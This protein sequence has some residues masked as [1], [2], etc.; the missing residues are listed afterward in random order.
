MLPCLRTFG[1]LILK[2]VTNHVKIISKALQGYLYRNIR[3]VVLKLPHFIMLKILHLCQKV[4]SH[5]DAPLLFIQST[6]NQSLNLAIS[7]SV[8]CLTVLR[9]IF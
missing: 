2:T 5:R 7:L 9:F 8:L 1:R 6:V 3:D 4:L